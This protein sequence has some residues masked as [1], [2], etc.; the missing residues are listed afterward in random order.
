MREP[1]QPGLE[2][3]L[4]VQLPAQYRLSAAE[5]A[6]LVAPLA[7]DE[8]ARDELALVLDRML[9]W[10]WGRKLSDQHRAGH[11][12]SLALLESVA[13]S[14]SAIVKAYGRM[15]PD[16]V[17][18]LELTRTG[19]LHPGT[20]SAHLKVAQLRE[21]LAGLAEAATDLGSKLSARPAHRPAQA[22]LH[23]VVDQLV[24]ALNERGVPVGTSRT[25]NS[26]R[27]PRLAGTGGELIMR[28]FATIDPQVTP[29]SLYRI[30]HTLKRERR[31]ATKGGTSN[32]ANSPR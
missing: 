29:A 18:G 1:G 12:E 2:V 11:A 31:S 15:Q 6:A 8:R 26:V 21:E 22:A 4:T 30:V 27:D 5:L 32:S 23:D 13:T 14:A 28:F 24:F 10:Y 25:L 19:A 16:F 7:V 20:R 9:G 17:A 3:L